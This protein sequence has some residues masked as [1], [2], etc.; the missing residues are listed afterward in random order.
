MPGNLCC[1]HL[2][3]ASFSKLVLY[4]EDELV[5]AGSARIRHVF[6]AEG[7]DDIRRLVVLEY[8]QLHLHIVNAYRQ[9]EYHA[10]LVDKMPK[11]CADGGT[12][13]HAFL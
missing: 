4:H 13:W 7:K 11:R 2:W 3:I 12:K 10:I 6:F 1:D 5:Y 8:G 9:G